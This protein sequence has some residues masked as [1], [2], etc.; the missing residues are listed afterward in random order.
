M[1]ALTD[2]SACTGTALPASH[3]CKWHL[4]VKR[5]NDLI[6]STASLIKRM[7]PSG[8]DGSCRR[9]LWTS[10]VADWWFNQHRSEGLRL[11]VMKVK[12]VFFNFNRPL[13]LIPTVKSV[14][15]ITSFLHQREQRAADQPAT[16]EVEDSLVSAAP[17]S[18]S[19]LIWR[20]RTARSCEVCCTETHFIR[21]V[22]ESGSAQSVQTERQKPWNRLSL[23]H[24]LK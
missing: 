21:C 5:G 17:A 19:Q 16:F 12:L 20:L 23:A 10:L 6:A 22:W 18:T 9:N 13:K 24:G 2:A 11:Y 4:F 3:L 15:V 8:T 7:S 1:S 14:R